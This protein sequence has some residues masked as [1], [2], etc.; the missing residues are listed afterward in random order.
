MNRREQIEEASMEFGLKDHAKTSED[1]FV[2]GAEWAFAQKQT[3]PPQHPIVQ[4]ASLIELLDQVVWES[5]MAGTAHCG[6]TDHARESLL[7]EIQSSVH[8]ALDQKQIREY[9]ARDQKIAQ[10]VEGLV[11]AATQMAKAISTHAEI[12]AK[13][14]IV[15]ALSKLEEANK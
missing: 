15:E 4:K 1:C 9:T 11:S 12:N 7:K 6:W 8:W 10:A 5:F 2:A 14:R 3:P 13:K